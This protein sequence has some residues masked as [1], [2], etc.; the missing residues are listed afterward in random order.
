MV[1]SPMPDRSRAMTQTKKDT[2]V[3]QVGVS[4]CVEK[5]SGQKIIVEKTSVNPR[6]RLKNRR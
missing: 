2:L 4:A 5:L 6:R 1:G 3:P